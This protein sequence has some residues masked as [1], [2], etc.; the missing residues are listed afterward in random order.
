[1]SQTTDLINSLHFEN[2]E[3]IAF[4]N[5]EVYKATDKNLRKTVII[6]SVKRD[7]KVRR[8]KRLKIPYEVFILKTINH[9]DGV[10]NLIEHIKLES[11]YLYVFEH[12]PNTVDL[13]S[14]LNEK[15]KLDENTARD[16]M[17]QFL[18]TMQKIENSKCYHLD[19]KIENLLIN[20]T[21]NIITVI[22][23]GSAKY[24]KDP[25]IKFF[26]MLT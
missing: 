19:I 15:G 4:S 11:E 24:V 5:N 13:W 3:L 14:H 18:D 10:V 25:K 22:D 21:T 12:L 20:T 9:I 23:F 2:A 8:N 26:N 16:I 7:S 17:K 1:M 6:K